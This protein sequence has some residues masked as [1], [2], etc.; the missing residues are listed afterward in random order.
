MHYCRLDKK[1]R[2]IRTEIGISWQKHPKLIP[3]NYILGC[4][5]ASQ[6]KG[7]CGLIGVGKQVKSPINFV[8]HLVSVG[9]ASISQRL[10]R[11]LQRTRRFR[12]SKKQT[13]W[14]HFPIRPNL[15][16]ELSEGSPGGGEYK[17]QARG[18]EPKKTSNFCPVL[19][20]IEPSRSVELGFIIHRIFL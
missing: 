20:V 2:F 18:R 10:Q 8:L 13:V 14:N 9:K 19:F 4:P 17:P 15:W 5:S 11:Q 1:K 6:N 16:I 3:A 7:L 12:N